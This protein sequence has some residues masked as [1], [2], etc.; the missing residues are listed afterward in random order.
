MVSVCGLPLMFTCSWSFTPWV[1][2]VLAAS[3]LSPPPGVRVA[4]VE[5]WVTT[6]VCAPLARLLSDARAAKPN[7]VP[8]L[9]SRIGPFAM[10]VDVDATVFVDRTDA[11]AA[12]WSTVKLMDPVSALDAA[13]AVTAAGFDDVAVKTDHALGFVSA[14]AAACTAL[15]F[16][17]SA[18]TAACWACTACCCDWSWV[19]GMFSTWTSCWIIELTSR[20]LPM[21]S[22]W[23]E[24]PL[25][26]DIQAPYLLV[27][28][29]L[30]PVGFARRSF[31]SLPWCY[32]RRGGDESPPRLTVGA[33]A[34]PGRSALQ[35][36][37][38]ALR[39][40]VRLAEHGGAG[41]HQDLVLGEVGHLH[42]HVGVPDLGVR[43]RQVLG[44][45]LEAGHRGLETVLL[46]TE[47]ARQTR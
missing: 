16:C 33:L 29:A 9:A 17:E 14:L 31:A 26:D 20:L 21:P 11:A 45:N 2:T 28:L 4:A 23:I 27:A 36:R 7:C 39:D 32:G 42:G 34:D 22:P 43:R 24:I 30:A 19:T 37:E 47:P 46:R 8:P 41:L 40:L 18:S 10:V 25:I 12:R 15:H 38:D 1:M 5:A 13:D 44:R 35:E 6:M 3:A